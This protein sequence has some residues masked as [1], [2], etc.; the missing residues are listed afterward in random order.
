MDDEQIT[1]EHP[2]LGELQV[3]RSAVK[4]I[5]YLKELTDEDE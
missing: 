5:R 1:L 4:Q 2:L 3:V